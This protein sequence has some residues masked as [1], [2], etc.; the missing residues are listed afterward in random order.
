MSEQVFLT[1][2][3][4]AALK[5]TLNQKG[6][7][8]LIEQ[9]SYIV[10]TFSIGIHEKVKPIRTI[11]A[12]DDFKDSIIKPSLGRYMPIEMSRALFFIRKKIERDELKN[13]G[14]IIPILIKDG[15][16]YFWVI[17]LISRMGGFHLCVKVFGENK[18]KEGRVLYIGY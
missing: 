3:E 5:E 12:T 14:D 9:E 4:L 16:M 10:D 1:R 6:Y 2:K 7:G 18:W 11:T 15:D 8:Y 17:G 13:P